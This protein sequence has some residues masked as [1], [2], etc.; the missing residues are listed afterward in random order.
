MKTFQIAGFPDDDDRV[1]P[2]NT[3]DPFGPGRFQAGCHE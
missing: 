2:A 1:F 3:K